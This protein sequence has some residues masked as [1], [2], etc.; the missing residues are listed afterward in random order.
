[1]HLSHAQR[2]LLQAILRQLEDLEA[3]A[4]LRYFRGHHL[5]QVAV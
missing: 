4:E 3:V 2:E 1:M 5:E